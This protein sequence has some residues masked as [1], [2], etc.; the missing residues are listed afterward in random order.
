MSRTQAE[1]L[2]GWR[3][4]AEEDQKLFEIL[5]AVAADPICEDCQYSTSQG[6]EEG[7]TSCVVRH[8]MLE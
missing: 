7:C 3:K 6:A 5:D 4:Q 1:F 8:V 2:L